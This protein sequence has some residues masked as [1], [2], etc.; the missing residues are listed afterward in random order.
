MFTPFATLTQSVQPHGCWENVEWPVTWVTCPLPLP[1]TLNAQHSIYTHV[2]HSF[3][4]NYQHTIKHS[5]TR[6]PN[7]QRPTRTCTPR[8]PVCLR[9][10]APGITPLRPRQRWIAGCISPCV[11]AWFHLRLW[12]IT[13]RQ[14][15][16]VVFAAGLALAFRFYACYANYVSPLVIVALSVYRIDRGWLITP[17]TPFQHINTTTNDIISILTST[18]YK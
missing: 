6:C 14:L 2:S 7:H 16:A 12:F 5:E 15:Y 13:T 9:S 3:I 11:S 10:P 8:A 17:P 1:H 4:T 18:I